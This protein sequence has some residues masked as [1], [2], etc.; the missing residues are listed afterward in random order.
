[1]KFIVRKIEKDEA[2]SFIRTRTI[3]FIKRREHE[4]VAEHYN[5]GEIEAIDIMEQVAG[6]YKNK[7]RAIN[8]SHA[9]KYL[10]RAPFKGNEEGDI[11]KAIDYLIRVKYG[12]WRDWKGAVE[13]E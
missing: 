9:L 10:I 3:Y 11:D 5:K 12:E 7:K 8:M 1:M 6:S 13:S 2:V 4:S